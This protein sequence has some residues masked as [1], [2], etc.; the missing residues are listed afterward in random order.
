MHSARLVQWVA[1]DMG[2]GVRWPM[3]VGTDSA[4]ARSFQ[5]DTCPSSK[6]RGCF[7]VRDSWVRELRDQKMVS[8][9]KIPRELNMADMLT[10]C[11]VKCK[12][13]DSIMRAQNFQQYKARGACVYKPLF[14]YTMYCS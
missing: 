11:L 9:D 4:Q 5:R 2:I 7:Q 14:R 8:V 12:F 3:V 1:E 6:L 10:H 13:K